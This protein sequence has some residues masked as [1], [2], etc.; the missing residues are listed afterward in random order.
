LKVKAQAMIH[1]AAWLEE[2]HGREAVARALS[3]CSRDVNERYMSAITIEWH[4]IAEFYEMLEAIE[5]TV[6]AG[7]GRTAFESGAYSARI[8]TRGLMKRSLFYLANAEFLLRKITALWSQFNEEGA[9]HLRH[10]DARRVTI[11][12][13]GV[14]VPHKLLC[15]SVTGWVQV[16]A[17][18]VGA[19]GSRTEH[20][21][22]RARGAQS[23]LYEV[24]W[25]ARRGENDAHERKKA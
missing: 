24:R 7:D 3:L 8:N 21:V 23:C 12:L 19:A 17:E 10:F 4:P 16:V 11:E 2:T 14:P 1:A 9:M 18:A 5:Q 15:A 13:E 22:C 25:D 20:S 6:G